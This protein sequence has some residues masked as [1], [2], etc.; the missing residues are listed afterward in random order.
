MMTCI[1]SLNL[2]RD[3]EE[4]KELKRISSSSLALFLKLVDR[5]E[6]LLRVRRRLH[7]PHAPV[8]LEPVP[9]DRPGRVDEERLSVGELA[10]DRNL[11]IRA[12]GR[13]HG[14]VAVA[15]KLKP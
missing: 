13:G 12:V 1:T 15:E 8:S 4:E 3:Q 7:V 10:E 2:T 6:N 14:S 5:F 9:F 11:E